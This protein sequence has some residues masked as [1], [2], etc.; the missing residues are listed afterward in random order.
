MVQLQGEVLW[1]P[2][3]EGLKVDAESWPGYQFSDGS[4]LVGL[5]S[6]CMM[7]RDFSVLDPDMSVVLCAILVLKP[8]DLGEG[9]SCT[10]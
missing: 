6:R 8:L 5:K 9:P 2:S 10:H 7:R 4:R 1:A 3:A